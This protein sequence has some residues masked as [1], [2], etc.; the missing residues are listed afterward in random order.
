MRT[1]HITDL[2]EIDIALIGVPFDG[3]VTNRH[4]PREEDR[5]SR[6]DEIMNNH[7]EKRQIAG[8]MIL[9]DK[10]KFFLNDPVSKY[11]PSSSVRKSRD[12][13]RPLSKRDYEA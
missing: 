9:W 12:R 8:A 6:I 4:G 10:G 13:D 11:I 3:A 7:V 2:S 5:F 1:P